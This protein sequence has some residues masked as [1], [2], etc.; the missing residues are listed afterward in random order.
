MVSLPSAAGIHF[1]SH[2]RHLFSFTL[3]IGSMTGWVMASRDVL[4]LAR[5]V[6]DRMGGY[7]QPDMLLLP[8]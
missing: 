3:L 8:K 2:V 5:W 1:T 7:G 4:I 6:E